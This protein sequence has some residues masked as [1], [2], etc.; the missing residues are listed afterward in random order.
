MDLESY[1][2]NAL[3]RH[4]GLDKPSRDLATQETPF[5][6]PAMKSLV[7]FIV[8]RSPPSNKPAKCSLPSCSQ[9]FVSGRYR[10]AVSPAMKKNTA[11][12]VEIIERLTGDIDLYHVS[13]FERIADL[14]DSAFLERI[15]PF[16]RFTN[17]NRL[18]EDYICAGAVER[19]VNE[20]KTRRIRWNTVVKNSY[21]EEE[22][23]L[24]DEDD[25]YDENNG[26]SEDDDVD[27]EICSRT[28]IQKSQFT[29]RLLDDLMHNAGSSRFKPYGLVPGMQRHQYFLFL[30]SLAPWESDG[31]GDT[32]EWNLFDTFLGQE[33]SNNVRIQPSVN[34]SAV[35]E[36][37]EKWVEL[38]LTP[39]TSLTHE[40]LKEKAG[41]GEKGCRAIRRLAVIPIQQ[42]PWQF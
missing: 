26:D 42:I 21:Q 35:L 9:V 22:Q 20:W 27:E 13:C 30:N 41:I 6:P 5:R 23:N 36:K 14:S 17:F 3:R 34:L 24:D 29:E 18:Q 1:E 7:S 38:V 25:M 8:E 40:Q 32:Q 28:T 19:L 10:V 31:P 16:T 33:E 11:Q 12:N 39:D 15:E 4:L 2:R 37:W